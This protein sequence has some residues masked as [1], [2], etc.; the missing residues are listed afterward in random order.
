MNKPH[1]RSQSS[2]KKK[3]KVYLPKYNYSQNKYLSSIK[4]SHILISVK[5][6]FF[7]EPSKANICVRNILFECIFFH[8]QINTEAKTILCFGMLL[9]LGSHIIVKYSSETGKFF[10]ISVFP[11]NLP[12]GT[13]F[14]L[15]NFAFCLSEVSIQNFPGFY[16]R[17]K[18]NLIFVLL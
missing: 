7:N 6:I 13:I 8:S 2:V 11:H 14:T 16:P 1:N 3:K 10:L 9:D 5:V 12:F 17:R 18:K 15:G 4:A